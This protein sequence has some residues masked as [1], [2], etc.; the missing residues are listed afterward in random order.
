MMPSRLKNRAWKYIAGIFSVC[1]ILFAALFYWVP[2]LIERQLNRQD[3]GAMFHK[4]TG[5]TFT[6]G[7]LRFQFLPAP[8]V[9]IPDGR[10]EIP[11]Q[12]HG[13]W[14]TTHF[15][16]AFSPLF[17]GRL[18]I[19]AFVLEEPEFTITVP[20]LT[21]SD[22]PA[23]PS[24][25]GTTALKLQLQKALSR[26]AAVLPDTTVEIRNGRIRADGLFPTPVHLDGFDLD[27]QL[28]PDRLRFDL[29]CRSN[30]WETLH[31]S[32]SLQPDTLQ[33]SSSLTLPNSIRQ[34]LRNSFPSPPCNGIPT[35]WT[36][37]LRRT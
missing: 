5:G 19:S 18:Q 6:S 8:H 37:T 30:M 3:L 32:G 2:S 7:K 31:L 4:A 26:M 21:D 24:T 14:R 9:V 16:P 12:L 33:G 29:R 22:S 25:D 10:I 20:P 35:H 15:Y 23:S 13:N 17:K 36:S 28:L 34:S 11:K 1:L 27:L